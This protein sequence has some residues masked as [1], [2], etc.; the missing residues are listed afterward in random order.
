MKKDKKDEDCCSSSGGSDSMNVYRKRNK[1][2]RNMF[3]ASIFL[4]IG[5]V[6]LVETVFGISIP[7]F[8]LLIGLWFV[9][10]GVSLVMGGFRM[11][12]FERRSS[13]HQ[14]IFSKSKFDIEN[15][16]REFQTVFG[17]S[18]LDLTGRDFSSQH[19]ELKVDTVFGDCNVMIKKGT[20]WKISADTVFGG[21]EFP[22]KNFNALG[23]FTHQ[24]ANYVEGKAGVFIRANTVFGRIRVSEVE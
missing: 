3:W 1:G 16:D 11:H 21:A 17:S 22:N 23:T 18:D 13:H 9:Y 4:V 15:T 14:A 24:S 19:E 6:L 10:M 7:V 8:R 12:A 20:P 2:R 5:I